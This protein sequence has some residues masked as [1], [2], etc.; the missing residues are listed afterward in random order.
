MPGLKGKWDLIREV[1]V[2]S[3]CN[4][5]EFYGF[6]RDRAEA[7]QLLRESIDQLKGVSHLE[8]GKYTYS[9]EGRETVRHLFRV[10]AGVDSLMVGE[11][12]ILGQVREAFELA[13]Q[14]RAAG[15]LLTRLFNSA[16]HVGKRA[17]TE[18]EIGRA[19]SR[20]PTQR[21][22]WPRRSWTGWNGTRSWSSVPGTREPWWLAISPRCTPS[23]SPS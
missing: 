10:A 1:V 17:R 16:L 14:H 15:A 6:V 7:D 19:R 3:T 2:L 5:T 20:W 13:D 21:W 23:S 4:R 11:S 12:Q 18:T 8:N 9:W 22:R